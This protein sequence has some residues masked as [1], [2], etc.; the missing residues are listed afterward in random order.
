MTDLHRIAEM[1]A[2]LEATT[3]KIDKHNILL[4]HDT[5]AVQLY[6]KYALDP[7]KKFYLRK[8]PRHKTALKSTV[9]FENMIDCLDD[10]S[11]RRVTGNDAIEMVTDL[12]CKLNAI[13]GDTFQRMLT[14]DLRCGTSVATVNKAF[15]DLVPTFDLQ[16][17]AQ[18]DEKK[19]TWPRI[20]EPKIDGMRAVAFVEGSNPEDVVFLTRSGKPIETM[21]LHAE[22]IV[23][24]FPVGTI[25]DGEAK[26]R[27]KGHED[28]MS[29]IK[30]KTARGDDDIVFYVFDCLSMAEFADQLCPLDL[31]SRRE[32][33]V[34]IL[35]N[36]NGEP[37]C[38]NIE[39]LPNE[40]VMSVEEAI[41]SFGRRRLEGHEGLILK[42]PKGK[43]DFKRSRTW[44]KMKPSETMDVEITGYEEGK[45]GKTIGK[46]GA[47]LFEYNGETCRAGG[48]YTDKQRKEFWD[49]RDKMVGDLMEVEFM[50]KTAK[51]KTR[52]CNFIKLR[53]Y[54]GEKC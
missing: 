21:T 53:T 44:M 12:L 43:Y 36:K 2:Q 40:T 23:E 30:R 54:K 18:W 38:S 20:S 6:L 39:V 17:A 34:P 22:Q 8:I 9:G 49:N 35:Q 13:D 47:F 10:L 41:E 15:P 27:I 48:G 1:L 29:A 45:K 28:S 31:I 19:A 46:L 7:Y 26:L 24:K 11:K 32:R 5:P 52:H 37:T 16:L 42:E 50:E 51:G 33:F 25:L 14:K 4:K 3:S